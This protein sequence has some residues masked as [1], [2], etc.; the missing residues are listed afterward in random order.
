MDMDDLLIQAI[1]DGDVALLAKLLRA[2][3]DVSVETGDGTLLHTLTTWGGADTITAAPRMAVMLMEAG[4]D[5]NAIDPESG[6]TPLMEAVLSDNLPL[7]RVLLEH[8]ADVSLADKEDGATALHLAADRASAEC[9]KLLIEHGADVNA[10]ETDGMTPLQWAVHF[11]RHR[12]A[13]ILLAHGATPLEQQPP[14]RW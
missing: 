12:I 3:A 10:R 13:E 6:R 5:V 8:G 4:V 2:G 11:K 7:V 14:H 9:V 1:E